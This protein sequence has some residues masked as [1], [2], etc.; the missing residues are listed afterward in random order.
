MTDSILYRRDGA[1]ARLLR[2]VERDDLVVGVAVDAG[3]HVAAHAAQSD[4]SDV[5][6]CLLARRRMTAGERQLANLI[7]CSR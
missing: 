3:D 4:Q 6:G 5:H 2:R 1:L 7:G